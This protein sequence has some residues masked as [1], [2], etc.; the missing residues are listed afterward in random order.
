MM[1]FFHMTGITLLARS[2]YHQGR[3]ALLP[4]GRPVTTQ[5]MMKLIRQTKPSTATFAASVLE[6]IYNTRNG[7]ETLE[8][9][10]YAF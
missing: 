3:L 5:L 2:I 7:L 6:D 9:L 1:H 8:M 10:E 4:T